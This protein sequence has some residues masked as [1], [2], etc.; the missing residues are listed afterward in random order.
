MNI[1]YLININSKYIKYGLTKYT[2]HVYDIRGKLKKI[3]IM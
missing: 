2:F 3:I 1:I